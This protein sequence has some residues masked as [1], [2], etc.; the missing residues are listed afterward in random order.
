MDSPALIT[1]DLVLFREAF[2]AFRDAGVFPDALIER[3]F[4]AAC[5][6]VSPKDGGPLR[7]R[8]RQRALN[9]MTAHL[10]HLEQLILSGS[11]GGVVQGATIDKVSVTLVP[12]PVKSQFVWWLNQS[13]YGQE[14]LAL[15]KSKA[16]GGVYIGGS[17][18]RAA[19]RK[20]GGGFRG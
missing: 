3:H 18:E 12:P 16:A 1:L 5:S 2:P 15:L 13:P 19:F 9:L 11:A 10:L 8:G 20:A 7:G 14:L 17:P 4:D 6:H